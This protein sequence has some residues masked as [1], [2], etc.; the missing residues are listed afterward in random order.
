MQVTGDRVERGKA[1]GSELDIPLGG[2]VDPASLTEASGTNCNQ[3]TICRATTWGI[4][5]DRNPGCL[6]VCKIKPHDGW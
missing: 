3:I 1:A 2:P 4:R 5:T 6:F